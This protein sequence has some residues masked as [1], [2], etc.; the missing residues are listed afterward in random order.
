[1]L[2]EVFE[3]LWQNTQGKANRLAHR[4][5]FTAGYGNQSE[6]DF[7]TRLRS[8]N[9]NF[10][11]DVRRKGARSWNLNYRPGNTYIG[12]LLRSEQISYWLLAFQHG[13]FDFGNRFDSLDDYQNWICH[14]QNPI[15]VIEYIAAFLGGNQGIIPCL[16]CVERSH[17][18]CHRTIVADLFIEKLNSYARSE[19]LR[20]WQVKHI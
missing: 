10:I 1:M 3:I 20:S 19:G 4:I 13:Q 6:P 18:K 16:L 12:H 9:V 17:V 11:L 14:D 5:L 2:L 8:F 7:L 15:R